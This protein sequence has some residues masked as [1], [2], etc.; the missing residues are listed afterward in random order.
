MTRAV[1]RSLALLDALAANPEPQSVTQLAAATTL[2]RVVVQ[3]LL[4]TLEQAKAAERT[5]DGTYRL[6]RGLWGLATAVVNADHAA[7]AALPVML[8]LARSLDV[9]VSLASLDGD[10]VLY[11]HRI[12]RVGGR[13]APVLLNLRFVP[14][15]TASG[16]ILVAL[17]PE[18]EWARFVHDVPQLT[19]FTI[20]DADRLRATLRLTR[21]RGYATVQ[22]E[23]VEGVTGVGLP[24]FGAGGE[25]VAALGFT[26]PGD[27]TTDQEQRLVAAGLPAVDAI[28][29]D[30]GFRGPRRVSLG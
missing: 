19:P 24:L 25:V 21:R 22:S 27:L 13:M 16:R 30:L 5:S 2:H 6:G 15:V 9:W 4:S 28:S 14:V 11:S 20:T 7:R 3:R 18:S 26:V 8:E 1:E 23:H 17:Q 12:D 29:A 10:A